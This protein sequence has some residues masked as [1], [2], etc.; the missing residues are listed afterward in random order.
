MT[1][2]IEI[3]ETCS[4]TNFPLLISNYKKLKSISFLQST[5]AG[6]SAVNLPLSQ[7]HK[8]SWDLSKVR[9]TFHFGFP[10]VF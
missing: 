8:G 4:V 6:D 3:S 7:T 5:S 9:E 10:F 2:N 1:E